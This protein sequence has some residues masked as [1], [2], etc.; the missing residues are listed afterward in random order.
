[1]FFH[2]WE[3]LA[4]QQHFAGNQKTDKIIKTDSADNDCISAKHQPETP[5]S[6]TTFPIMTHSYA[7][8]NLRQIFFL[9]QLISNQS[10][11]SGVKLWINKKIQLNFCEWEL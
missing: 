3:L 5:A 4:L 1:M 10:S 11:N 9:A 8:R 2:R 7:A 6:N